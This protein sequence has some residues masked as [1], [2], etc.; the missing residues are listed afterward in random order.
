MNKPMTRINRFSFFALML[1]CLLVHSGQADEVALDGLANSI[2]QEAANKGLPLLSIVLVDEDGIVWSHSVG[3]RADGLP[4]D[5]Q[6]DLQDRFCL[7]V[8]H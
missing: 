1:A 4:A 7:Q 2:E 5:A 8:V 6:Y 3:Q